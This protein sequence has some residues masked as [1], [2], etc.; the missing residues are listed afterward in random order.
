VKIRSDVS[1]YD[2]VVLEDDGFCG[3]SAV[4]TNGYNPRAAVSRKSEYLRTLVKRGAPRAK[5]AAV[6]SETPPGSAPVSASL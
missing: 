1:V 5:L 2:A 4:F 3:P 6:A